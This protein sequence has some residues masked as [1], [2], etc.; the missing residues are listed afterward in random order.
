MQR[1]IREKSSGC[2]LGNDGTWT[3][4]YAKARNFESFQSLLFTASRLHAGELEEVL[5]MYDRPGQYDLALRILPAHGSATI[6]ESATEG[7]APQK[8]EPC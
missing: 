1:L 5:V 8:L 6:V 3:P 4:E 2:F 7:G